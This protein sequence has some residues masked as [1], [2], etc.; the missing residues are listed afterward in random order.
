MF[1]ILDTQGVSSLW[2]ALINPS[3]SRRL[4]WMTGGTF[5]L[6]AAGSLP[7]SAQTTL[8][9]ETFS[10]PTVGSA[11]A[12]NFGVANNSNPPCLTAATPIANPPSSGTGTGIPA[13]NSAVVTGPA[14]PA[15]SGTLRL[16]SAE[17][18]QATFVLSNQ[19]IASGQGLQISFDFFSY[20]GSG[21]DGLSFFLQDATAPATNAVGAFGG[22]L[23]Y[24]PSTNAGL[25]G[26]P[27]G[28]VG[29]GFDEFGNFSS[30]VDQGKGGGG[31]GLV[32]DS[33][34]IRGPA[35]GG[36]QYLTGTNS[37]PQG[38]DVP[39]ATTRAA[40][41]RTARITLTPSGQI[42]VDIDFG[43]GF[44]NV[45]APTTLPA[46]PANFRFGF[47]S[48]TGGSTNI[49]EI[50]NLGI[51]TLSPNLNITK[52]GPATGLTIG[53]P[54][55]Y[56]LNVANAANAG[57]TA[58]P[59]V[60]PNPITVTD[61][62]PAGL[63]FVSGTG[64]GWTC[65]AVGQVVTCFYNGPVIAPGAAAPPITIT[66]LPTPAAGT[67]AVNSAKVA[68][69]G[70][71]PD[72][73]PLPPNQNL[74]ADNTTTLTVP[75]NPSV[76]LAAAKTTALVD[77]NGNGIAD[78]GETLTYNINISNNGNVAS[79]NTIFTDQ[80]PAGTTYVPNSTRLNNA[81]VADT[82][83]AMPFSG[84]GSLVNNP[85]APA[86]QVA[87]A[88]TA[89]V[90]FQVTINQPPNVTQ[91][92]NQGTVT[93][94]QQTVPLPTDDPT[95]PGAADP[96][97]IPVSQ[98]IVGVPNF[99]MTKLITNVTRSGNVLP[100]VNFNAPVDLPNAAA[101]SSAFGALG[102][103]FQGVANISGD[104]PLQSGDEVEYTVYFLSNGGQ[105]STNAR[106]CDAIPAGTT[107]LPNS[108]GAATGMLLN[109]GG[110]QT[111][112]TN[113]SDTDLGA[114]FS[115]LTAVT[116]PCPN[117]NNPTGAVLFPLG[118]VPNVAPN[119]AGFVRFRVKVD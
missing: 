36:Y 108:F 109:Q 53:Q 117:T 95:L 58:D 6:L 68:T 60:T 89:T 9:N 24:A 38:I 119:N 56:I 113:A 114:F 102:V 96:T 30:P 45:I 61:T 51:T 33:V 64:T 67:S 47:A 10:N 39:T 81:V 50:S 74:T 99:L 72:N 44:V 110:T 70:D 41:K 83:N 101:F 14:D 55:A 103:P 22:S 19:I 76:L 79:T 52:T 66:V 112:L 88:G 85:G 106:I 17:G 34:A 7:V 8:V 4:S 118:N 91:I 5:L 46:P 23:G 80:I 86:G 104:N 25:P 1:S 77:T 69:P 87:I 84:S 20:G 43:A 3:R 21:A 71:D 18:N 97:V 42:S 92:E 59:A 78:P 40:A 65:S 105:N 16:T 90:Q 73:P 13:C 111:P 82:A 98:P 15:A 116:V 107:F 37:L 31:P 94:D 2:Q 93:S 63:N 32:V 54:G 100:G 27:G 12:F 29:V 26:L 62:L 48:S 11:A 35:A 49:H 57:P 28:Y 75:V 115:P